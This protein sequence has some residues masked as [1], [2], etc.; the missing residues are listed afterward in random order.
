M[1]NDSVYF[2]KSKSGKEIVLNFIDNL[3]DQTQV[4]IR[5]GMRLLKEHGLDLLASPWIKKIRKNP[6]IFELRVT[7][8]IQVRFLFCRYDHKIFLVLN[9]FVKK[10]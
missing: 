3:D 8:E 5:N 1:S 9:V 6:D 7:G 2:Y 4:R 10:T